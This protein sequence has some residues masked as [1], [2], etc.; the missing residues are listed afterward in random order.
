MKKLPIIATGMA[1]FLQHGHAQQ[2]QT[3]IE[4]FD[5]SVSW[6]ITPTGSWRANTFYYLPGSSPMNPKSLHGLVPNTAGDSTILETAI[7]DCTDYEYVYLQFSHICKVSID[8]RTRIEYSVDMGGGNMGPWTP[9]PWQTYKGS[10]TGY[11][12]MGFNAAS[13]PEWQTAD[14]TALPDQSWWKKELFDLSG[15]AQ[16]TPQL[17]FRFIIKHGNVQGS[18]IG[19]GWLLENFQLETA[20]YD[21]TPPTV[22]FIA[23]CIRDTVYSTGPWEINAK[24]KTNTYAPI[25][26]PWLNYTVSYNGTVMEADS[27]LMTPVRGDSLWKVSMPQFE[28]E[29]KIVYAIVGKDT[30]GNVAAADSGYAIALPPAKGIGGTFILQEDDSERMLHPFST[31]YGYSRS[32]TIYPVDEIDPQAIGYISSIA[33]R[34]STPDPTPF[35]I[36]VWLKTVPTTKTAWD[37]TTDDYDWSV[38]TQDATLVY[39]GNFSAA[40]AGWVDIPLDNN[41][42]YYRK[43]NLVVFFEQNCGGMGCYIVPYYYGRMSTENCLWLKVSDNTPPTTISPTLLTFRPDLRINVLGYDRHNHSATLHSIDV[44]TIAVT[45]GLSVPVV[46]TVK[47]KGMQ[48]LSSA[49]LSYTVNGSIPKDTLINFSPALPWDFNKQVSIGN[50]FPQANKFDT[51]VAWIKLP[52]GQSDSTTW[53]DTLTKVIYG[54]SDIVLDFIQTPADTVNNRGPY[55]IRARIYSL[56]GTSLGNVFFLSVS[57]TLGGVTSLDTLSMQYLGANIWAATIPSKQKG[58]DVTYAIELTDIS[59]NQVKATGNYY[60]KQQGWDEQSRYVVVGEST[61]TFNVM[62][63]LELD[64][65]T[66]SRQ[67]YFASELSDISGGGWITHLAWDYAYSGSFIK[68]NQKCYFKAVDA[69]AVTSGYVDPVADGAT[70]VWQGVLSSEVG[71]RIWTEIALDKPFLLPPD[72]NLLIYWINED[73]RIQV[74][75]SYNFYLTPTSTNTTI[76]D[77]Q[78]GRTVNGFIT[79]LRPNARFYIL[80]RPHTDNSVA[81]ETINSPESSVP[82]GASLPIHISIRN[83]GKNNLTSFQIDWTRNG[84][85]QPPKTYSGNLPEDFT[86]TITIGYYTPKAGDIDDFVVWVSMPNGVTDANTYDDTLSIRTV[87]CSGIM[88]GIYR[89]GS[90]P[91]ATY[92]DL[93]TALIQLEYC[94]LAGKVTLQLEDGIYN[95]SV[96]FSNISAKTNDTIELI[97]LSGNAIIEATTFGINLGSLSNVLI[98]GITINLSGTGHGI[99]LGSGNNIEINSCYINLD[100]T[101]G[102]ILE[103]LHAGI[104]KSNRVDISHNVRIL[105]NVITGGITGILILAEGYPFE[106]N[107]RNTDWICDGNTVQKIYDYGMKMDRSTNFISL[108]NNKIVSINNVAVSGILFNNGN[109]PVVQGN[110]IHGKYMSALGLFSLNLG[111][112]PAVV[113]NNEIIVAVDSSSEYYYACSFSGSVNIY[114]NSV[115]VKET[116]VSSSGFGAFDLRYL[117]GIVKN[118]MII[119]THSIPIFTS[120][121]SLIDSNNII[122][123]HNNYYTGGNILGNYEGITQVSNINEW[124]SVSGEVGAVS[125]LPDFLDLS[126][127]MKVTDDF[128]YLACPSLPAVPTDIENTS[129]Q[130]ATTIMG[131]YEFTPSAI[132][133]VKPALVN[134][135]REAVINQYVPIEIE[136]VNFSFT[137]VDSIEFAYSFNGNAPVSYTYRPASPL[138]PWTTAIVPIGSLQAVTDTTI[139]IWITQV[140][141][142]N[143]SL[144]DTIYGAFSAI[145]LAEF[146]PPFFRDTMFV[147]SYDVNI[148]IFEKTGAPV[149]TPLLQVQMELNGNQLKDSFPMTESAGIWRATIPQLYY[150][151]KVVYF[152]DVADNIGNSMRLIDSAYIVFGKPQPSDYIYFARKD[153]AGDLADNG[154]IYW[155][156]GAYSRSLFLHSELEGDNFDHTRPV[157][158]RKIAYYNRDILS[159]AIIK[160]NLQI[161]MQLTDLTAD[162]F[163]YRDPVTNGSTL[164]YQGS[165]TSQAYWNEIELTTP[166]YLPAGANLLVYFIGPTA[167][168]PSGNARWAGVSKQD[169]TVYELALMPG[170]SMYIHS[171]I[172]PL[173]RFGLGEPTMY[174]GSNLMISNMVSPANNVEELCLSGYSPVKIA[175]RN[176]G[177]ND[178]NF[179]TDPVEIVVKI[180]NPLG[181][182]TTCTAR[183]IYGRLLSNQTDTIEIVPAIPIMY[184]GSYE[185]KAYVSS[186][187]DIFP[188]DDTLTYTYISGRIS[189][190]VDENFSGSNLPVEFL[191]EALIGTNTWTPYQPNLSFAVQP[192]FGTGMLRYTGTKGSLA[193]LSTRPLDMYGTIHPKLEFWYYHDTATSELDDSYTAIKLVVDGVPT[194]VLTVYKRGNTQGWVSYTVDLSS[195]TLNQCILIEFESMNKSDLSEQYIDRIFIT[196]DQELAVSEIIVSPEIITCDIKNKDIHVVM[197]TTTNHAIDFSQNPTSLALEISGQSTLY[198]SLTGIIAGNTLDTIQIA[199]NIDF[200][201]GVQVLK[202]YLSVP[203]DANPLNDT[204]SRTLI[205]NPDIAIQAIPTTSGQTNTDCI[206]SNTEVNQVVTIENKGNLDVWDISI[207]LEI[208]GQDGLLEALQDTLKGVVQADSSQNLTFAKTYTVPNEETYNV[209]VKAKLE[210]DVYL[211]DNEHNIMECA[212]VDT[213][214]IDDSTGIR[215]YYSPTFSLGQNIPNPADENTRIEYSIPEDG[216]IIFTVYSITGQI[217]HVEKKDSPAGK[218]NLKYN[219]A[220]LANGVYYY[221][222]EYKGERLVKKMSVHLF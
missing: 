119:T 28:V 42:L 169:R 136:V 141:G 128:A 94:G 215:D 210:C 25:E 199:S 147:S 155:N 97:A 88:S 17:Q 80:G 37:A 120:S 118:N 39:D 75:S 212:E 198:H 69:I 166:F 54:Q 44:E 106:S 185:I 160:P 30:L 50:Y 194:T 139:A 108:S 114:H 133:T 183:I 104:Y 14:N 174:P 56:S 99:I 48:P 192:T 103:D 24:V 72:K 78:F 188:Y 87:A 10:A 67:L 22:Q 20:T 180:T 117:D 23:P 200:S 83:D 134:F 115:Y 84:E 7:Y 47:N 167:S 3:L 60:I 131:A 182:D 85:P 98:K 107:A 93:A 153:T 34:V 193:K 51:I 162:Y 81:L 171:S 205:I 121:R 57:S 32:M 201:T 170:Y 222:M 110:K 202:V 18:Q 92:P 19:Y 145:P 173:M 5:G 40:P 137:A 38:A 138:A 79:I 204:T 187:I 102:G 191:S 29:T 156:S 125:V 52:N 41:F 209:V 218:N 71:G 16:Y 164:V 221:S 13:Y 45:P 172:C 177:Q 168:F 112:T 213:V 86:D 2:K 90:S 49:T 26:N 55:E 163:D 123:S 186:P 220:G 207:E 157:I 197:G 148:S 219:T 190:P 8:D 105:N 1:L 165:T 76:F 144:N 63:P 146:V 36:K 11:G 196:S 176:F 58:T 35:P 59:G 53:D 82:V 132:V 130:Y 152:V 217:L 46:V 149:S 65:A 113:C 195:Y 178:Y 62:A 4:D 15:V 216:Q 214:D 101:I 73:H 6:S 203:I 91:S 189:L 143:N 43:D 9:L 161:Y 154:I 64:R 70:L 184:A 21:L 33:L 31:L 179:A 66:W 135:P 77:T 27:I 12:G 74:Y 124:A 126:Q 89:I 159:S 96:D 61:T 95:E 151:S 208:Y 206:G 129:R 175:I 150:N 100:T 127:S 111:I 68:E 211:Y 140:N 116:A 181:E 122:F 109:I 158:I 142:G